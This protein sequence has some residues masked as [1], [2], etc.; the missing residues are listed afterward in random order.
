MG[1][2]GEARGAPASTRLRLQESQWGGFGGVSVDGAALRFGS[3]CSKESHQRRCL[4]VKRRVQS[5]QIRS[6]CQR[7]KTSPVPDT[8]AQ[9]YPV[10]TELPV[11]APSA[12]SP[13]PAA[14]GSAWGW[15]SPRGSPASLPSTKD[16]GPGIAPGPSYCHLVA[17]DEIAHAMPCLEKPCLWPL[18]P[19][20]GGKPG[21]WLSPQSRGVIP[22]RPKAW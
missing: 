15:R 21:G 17:A 19:N 3:R 16:E 2:P 10:R 8:R 9:P 6:R 22:A 14:R 20:C 4:L 12:G 1:E 18:Q 5:C 13:K 7:R 11:R